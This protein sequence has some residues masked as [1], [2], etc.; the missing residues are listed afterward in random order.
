[1]QDDCTRPIFFSYGKNRE[2]IFIFTQNFQVHC[3]DFW[4][5]HFCDKSTL[6]KGQAVSL[7]FMRTQP[8][9]HGYLFV[10]KTQFKILSSIRSLLEYLCACL[11]AQFFSMPVPSPE[12]AFGNSIF[13]IC[14]NFVYELHAT[15]SSCHFCKEVK[16]HHWQHG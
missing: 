10:E 2:T 9:T 15:F 11:K 8:F 16:W 6:V 4:I 5:S 13:M 3:G 1:M 7:H 12:A 14:M